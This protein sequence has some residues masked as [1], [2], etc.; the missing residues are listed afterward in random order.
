MTRLSHHALPIAQFRTLQKSVFP[1]YFN[2]QLLLIIV[3]AV[4]HPLHSLI[5]LASRWSELLPVA[6]MFVTSSLN[7]AVYGP[8]TLQAM[9]DQVHQGWWSIA[10]SFSTA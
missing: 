7:W 3:V 2:L 8:R 5:S 6:I 10:I 9:M 4:T 1:A